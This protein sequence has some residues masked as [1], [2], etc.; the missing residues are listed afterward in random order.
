MVNWANLD[1]NDQRDHLARRSPTP[2][3]RRMVEI[4]LCPTCQGHDVQRHSVVGPVSHWQCKAGNGC[5]NWKESAATGS[6]GRVTLA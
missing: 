6:Q 1:W 2:A 5:P 3:N 4:I